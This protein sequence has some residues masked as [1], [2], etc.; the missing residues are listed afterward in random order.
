MMRGGSNAATL[1]QR[2]IALVVVLWLVALLALMAVSQSAAVRTETLVVGNLVESATAR[3]AAYAGLQ[4]A[5][6]DLAKPIPARD[7]S[8]DSSVYSLRFGTAQLAVAITD[9]S[10]KVD[11]NMAP[12][13]LLGKLLAASGVEQGMIEALVDAILD[14]RDRDSLRRLNGAEEEDY[15]VA[16]LDYGPRNGPFQSKQEFAL[17]LGVD[18]PLYHAVAD[19]LTIHSGSA[20][21]NMSAA[22]PALKQALMANERVYDEGPDAGDEQSDGQ[23]VVPQRLRVS[24]GTVF[25]ITVE[26]RLDSGVRERLEAVVR[27]H[28]V[29]ANA[30]LRYEFLRWRE[31]GYTP[32]ERS[33]PNP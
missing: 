10:G 25:T 16:G 7:M 27:L 17:I 12:A 22:S 31:G 3:A 2:G 13:S 8:T 1:R 14:W 11:L 32:T 6:A 5:I 24:A 20:S 18:A 30:P 15:R 19:N 33:H 28:P 23:D 21:I 4:L 9:E 29:R 26:V